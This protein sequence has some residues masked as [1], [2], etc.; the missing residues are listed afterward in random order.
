[1]SSEFVFIP[2]VGYRRKTGGADRIVA[3]IGVVSMGKGGFRQ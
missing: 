3:A 1:M 2:D